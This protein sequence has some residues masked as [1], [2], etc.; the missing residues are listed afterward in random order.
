M[1]TITEQRVQTNGV[2]LN[3]ASAGSG[4]PVLLLHGFPDRWQLWADQLEALVEAGH[5]VIAPDLRGFGE[6]DKPEPVEAYRMPVLVADVAGVLDHFGVERAAVV[7]HD[8]GAGLAWQMAF[9]MPERV[10]RLAVL[11]VGHGGTATVAGV[12]QRQLSWYMLWFLFPGVAE[13]ALPAEDWRFFREWGWDGAQPGENALCDRQIADLGR[14][15]ALPAALN[16][17][18]ANI[19]PMHYVRTEQLA[20]PMVSCPTMGVWSAGDAFLDEAQ[21][22]ESARFVTGPWRYH[23]LDGSH[24]IPATAAS[25]VADLLVD[26]TA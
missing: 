8:W 25:A 13:A 2:T 10:E 21:M 17:Y 11:S 18:R 1:V 19:S 9:R 26:F 4:S 5:Q 22:Q 12:R 23:R 7:G 15:G 16:W 3:V 14:P 6:S 20:G 24:W